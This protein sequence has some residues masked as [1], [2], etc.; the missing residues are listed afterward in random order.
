MLTM[1]DC[2]ARAVVGHFRWALF[3]DFDELLII[4]PGWTAAALFEAH[5]A[6]SFGG[7]VPCDSQHPYDAARC[8]RTLKGGRKI[9][10]RT[11]LDTSRTPKEKEWT[12]PQFIHGHPLELL[13]PKDSGV[14][15]ARFRNC[16]PPRNI[17]DPVL[18]NELTYQAALNE[19][20]MPESKFK[21]CPS[22]MDKR[23]ESFVW[24]Y[25]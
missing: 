1:Q 9:A 11:D 13:L 17:S 25:D 8:E 2:W 22:I 18:L 19:L 15:F 24:S 6:L 10:L 23:Q 16:H 12:A 20:Q 4:P 7:H 5:R 14:F 21:L 3:M